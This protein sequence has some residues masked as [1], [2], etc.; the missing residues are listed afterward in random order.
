MSGDRGGQ[1][2]RRPRVISRPTVTRGPLRELKDLLYRLYLEAGPPTL[3][4]ITQWISEDESLPVRRSGTLCVDVWG[5]RS[6]QQ[7]SM[8]SHRSPRSWQG[9]LA[10]T[11]QT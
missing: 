2:V 9:G 3:D 10:G 5:R 6:C 8:T 7:A 4:E 1:S 11:R